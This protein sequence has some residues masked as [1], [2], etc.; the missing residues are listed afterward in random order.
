MLLEAMRAAVAS[1]KAYFPITSSLLDEFSKQRE[2]R[3]QLTMKIVDELSLGIAMVPEK[4]RVSI[5]VERF[6]GTNFPHIPPESREIWTQAYMSY[7]C[8]G[9]PK[10]STS[11]VT[12]TP[13]LRASIR[14]SATRRPAASAAK[15]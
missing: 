12:R 14:A 5:E 10:P 13:R 6:F 1:K 2:E 15:Q 7:G 11:S 8:A 9:V 3:Y 4:E